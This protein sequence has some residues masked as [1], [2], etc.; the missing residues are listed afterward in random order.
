[1]SSKNLK[2]NID[3]FQKNDS[4]KNDYIK[5]NKPSKTTI[6]IKVCLWLFFI[7]LFILYIYLI[8]PLSIILNLIVCGLNINR[9][10]PNSDI[11]MNIGILAIFILPFFS[12]LKSITK[13]LYLTSKFTDKILYV[14][15]GLIETIVEIPLTI[16]Y[17][18]Y[19]HSIYLIDQEGPEQ[20]INPWLIFFPTDYL[21]SFLNIFKNILVSGYFSYLGFKYY[22][23]NYDDNTM[24][25]IN[26][27]TMMMIV[28][29]VINIV[30]IL[31]VIIF[32]IKNRKSPLKDSSKQ[33][34]NFT[35]VNVEMNNISKNP[36]NT[37]NNDKDSVKKNK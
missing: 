35:S 37:E 14:I 30:G 17:K 3:N 10:I 25:F 20:L 24:Q 6:R 36:E 27:F 8:R 15:F 16:F 34:I 4:I 1:M 13:M 11:M 9:N 31:F 22:S 19:R 5:L 32:R 33:A 29:N 23:I 28:F 2:P 21:S 7:T 12:F 26:M 18:S